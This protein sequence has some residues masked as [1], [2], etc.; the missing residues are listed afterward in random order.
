MNRPLSPSW[1]LFIIEVSN[2]FNYK[3]VQL[4]WVKVHCSNH[5]VRIFLL[6]TFIQ[7]SSNICGITH[8]NYLGSCVRGWVFFWYG[9]LICK[10]KGKVNILLL[11]FPEKKGICMC[12]RWFPLSVLLDTCWWLTLT[13]CILMR[14][15]QLSRYCLRSLS[16]KTATVFIYRVCINV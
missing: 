5:E 11:L 12:L 6:Q 15:P 16:W 8:N 14:F 10:L 7:V 13:L 1:L 3:C 2:S 4:K 9:P